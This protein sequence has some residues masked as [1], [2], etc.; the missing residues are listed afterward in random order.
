MKL[1]YIFSRN[2]KIGSKIISFFSGLLIKDLEK[3]PSHVALLIEFNG[4]NETF[5]IE[6]VMHGGVRILPYSS[7]KKINEECY[8]ITCITP[9]KDINEVFNILSIIWNKKYDWKG[10][11]FFALCFLKHFLFK[12]PFPKENL[13]NSED[14]YFC[15]EAVG[16]LSGYNNYSMTTPAK[17][18]SDFL[19]MENK[20]VIK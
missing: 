4:L 12:T 17:M 15:T 1:Y 18:C 19:K 3:T 9:F 8:K 2:K 20:I 13:W 10:L 7:W 14:S 16:K 6:S 5:I 11:L